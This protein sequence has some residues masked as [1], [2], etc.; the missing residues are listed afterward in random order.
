MKRAS[1]RVFLGGHSYGSRQ[2]M[3]LAA[4]EP[5]LVDGLLLLSYPLHPPKRPEQLR[6]DHFPLLRTPSLFVHGSRDGF[7]SM[8]ELTAVLKLIPALTGLVTVQGAGHELVSTRTVGD[9]TTTVVKTFWN[10]V[11]Q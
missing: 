11:T 3:M 8:E 4:A 1:G 6:T 7:G 10:F 2:A 9:V 5:G